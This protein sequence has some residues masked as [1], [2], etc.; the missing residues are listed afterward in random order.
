M[1]K[2]TGKEIEEHY[3]ILPLVCLTW[4]A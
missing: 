1:Y 4:A 3:I 2:I